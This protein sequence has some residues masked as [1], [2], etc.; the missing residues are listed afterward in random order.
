MM[1][2]KEAQNSHAEA[3]TIRRHSYV[4]LLRDCSE[5]DIFSP[6]AAARLQPIIGVYRPALQAEVLSLMGDISTVVLPQNILGMAQAS[7]QRGLRILHDYQLVSHQTL[8]KA[9][10]FLGVTNIQY[11]EDFPGLLFDRENWVNE[12]RR[13]GLYKGGQTVPSPRNERNKYIR[14]LVGGMRIKLKTAQNLR[15]AHAIGKYISEEDAMKLELVRGVSHEYGHAIESGLYL[16]GV[17]HFAV[18]LNNGMIH[19]SEYMPL[20][21]VLYIHD[22]YMARG[23]EEAVTKRFL[24]DVKAWQ[25]QEVDSFFQQS[26]HQKYTKAQAVYGLFNHLTRKGYNVR[27]IKYLQQL[28]SR[29]ALDTYSDLNPNAYFRD[30]F[31]ILAYQTPPYSEEDLRLFNK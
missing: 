28:V 20:E 26:F 27:D 15:D 9:S 4:S 22:E 11:D 8:K 23:Y 6:D 2:D 25:P 12:A 3:E 13:R 7:F 19:G 18:A 21:D 16:E 5:I 31:M 10:S 30:L 29:V 24:L 14:L 1:T 17:D